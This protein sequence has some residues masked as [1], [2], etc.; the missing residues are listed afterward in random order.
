MCNIVIVNKG[1][2]DLESVQDFKK[3]FSSISHADLVDESVDDDCCLCQIDVSAIFKEN[4]IS[5]KQD[6]LGDF[7]VGE[8]DGIDEFIDSFISA[9][10]IGGS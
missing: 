8:L 3:H 5:Y 2:N 9:D 6:G 7:Y 4:N 1:E 10:C